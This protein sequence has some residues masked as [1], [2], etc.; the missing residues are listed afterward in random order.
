MPLHEAVGCGI[1]SAV[2][3]SRRRPVLAVLAM[4]TFV[5]CVAFG[6]ACSKAA[7]ERPYERPADVLPGRTD[8]DEA[9]F[10]EPTAPK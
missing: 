3:T 9:V 10:F 4:L 8:M 7:A 2:R 6:A 5:V 1:G